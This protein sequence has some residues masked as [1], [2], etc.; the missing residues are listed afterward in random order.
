[1]AKAERGGRIFID[2]LR[3]ERGATAVAPFSL[4]A[5]PGA[6]VAVPVT[7]Q[8][9]ATLPSAQAFGMAAALERRLSDA[10]P[11]APATL[12]RA[13]LDRLGTEIAG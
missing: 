7:W 4:R 13:V 10:P 2:Y 6:P 3:N 1:L 11:P 12:G 5:R 8:E 9:L